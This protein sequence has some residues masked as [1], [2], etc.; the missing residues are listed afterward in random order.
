MPR[1]GLL[2]GHS[3]TNDMFSVASVDTYDLTNV[4]G[5]NASGGSE[6]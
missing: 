5:R 3:E 6:N 1:F 2:L 4:E